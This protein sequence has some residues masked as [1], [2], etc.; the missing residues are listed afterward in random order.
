M[1][2]ILSTALVLFLS[3]ASLALSSCGASGVNS[4]PEPK[5]DAQ[6]ALR[7]IEE[8]VEFGPRVPGSEAWSD[9]RDYLMAYFDSLGYNVQR[10]DYTHVDYV[11]GQTVPLTNL[12]ITQKVQ[13]SQ[14]VS[15]NQAILLCAHW[16]SRPRCERDPDPARRTDSLPAAND[17]AS[18]VAMLMELAASIKDAPPTVPVAFVLFDGE[19]WGREGDS[20][21]YSLGAKKFASHS[22]TKL[23]R[24]AILFDIIAHPTA[25]FRKE[26]F[27]EKFASAIN[28]K[29]W[30]AAKELGIQRFIDTVGQGVIDDH[31]P[32]LNAGLP[33]IDIIDMNYKYWHTTLDTPD[34]C[35][36]AAL[37]EVGS[38]ILRVL[39]QEQ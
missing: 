3:A 27:S 17:G 5:F 7:F 26:K 24:Y 1:K 8:Q 10:N 21:Q 4:N 25:K 14:D 13:P 20:N 29:V 16:D 31:L 12:L 11:T 6:R 15:S 2:N 38:V 9:C 18:G 30:T 32:L 23:Y 35:D 28:H 36:S 33:T 39:Y 37:H 19:D 34:K 22:D